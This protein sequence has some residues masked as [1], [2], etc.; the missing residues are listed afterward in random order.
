MTPAP[1]F[2]VFVLVC[3]FPALAWAQPTG[4]NPKDMQLGISEPQL[5]EALMKTMPGLGSNSREM[6]N[7]QSLKA[8]MMPPRQSPAQSSRNCYAVAACLE[9]YTNYSKNYKSN[10]SPEYIYLNLAQDQL[11][12]A[13]AFAAQT[14]TVSAAIMPFGSSTVSMA[15]RNTDKFQIQNYLHLYRAE[16]RPRQK[17]LETRQALMRG[18]PVIV[19]MKVTADFPFL[20][21]LRTWEPGGDRTDQVEPLIVVSYSEERQAF[22]VLSSYGREWASNGYLWVSYND[23]ARLVNN[24]YVLIPEENYAQIGQ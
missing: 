16:A 13:L 1:M 14:G 21:N 3:I 22:E 4:M 17:I 6:L 5:I 10:L 8:F 18:N 12:E 2:Y 20:K 19:E 24:A 23:F 9:F 11:K 7:E 15:V